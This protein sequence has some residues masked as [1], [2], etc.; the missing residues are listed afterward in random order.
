MK[1]GVP[2]DTAM[3]EFTTGVFGKPRL[4]VDSPL[5]FSLSYRRGWI[6]IAMA[7]SPVGVDVELMSAGIDDAS[8]IAERFFHADEKALLRDLQG[9]E[10]A[11]AFVG[12]WT[13]KEALVKAAGL[14]VDYMAATPAIKSPV[15]LSD[16]TGA[17]AAY[18]VQQLA[19]AA[20]VALAVAIRLP[21]QDPDTTW[22]PSIAS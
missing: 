12:I 8:A 4:A 14:G 21:D 7:S 3:A 6:A 22:P 20:D 9:D 17:K 16:A 18:H 2:R 5:H 13:R 10:L 15:L 11:R 19:C 1:Q